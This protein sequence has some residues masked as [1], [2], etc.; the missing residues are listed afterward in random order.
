M[1]QLG[2][3]SYSAAREIA[4]ESMRSHYAQR[5]WIHGPSGRL[6]IAVYRDDQGHIQRRANM[7]GGAVELKGEFLN[8]FKSKNQLTLVDFR[9]QK[10]ASGKVVAQS[11][12]LSLYLKIKNSAGR[13][14]GFLEEVISLDENFR[15]G[16][17]S[18]LGLEVFFFNDGSDEVFSGNSNIRLYKADFFRQFLSQDSSAYFDLTIQGDPFG[19][20]LQPLSWGDGYFFVGLGASKKASRSILQNVKYAFF[21]VVGLIILLLVILSLISS[22][23]MLRPLYDL[24][25]A[26]QTMDINKGRIE[27]KSSG[28]NELGLLVDSFNEMSRRVYEAQKDLR[29]KI[30]ELEQANQEI[31]ETQARLVHTAKM[32]SLGQLVAGIAHELNNPIGFIYSNMSHLNDYSEKLVGLI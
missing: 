13:T 29:T 15:S 18:R 5:L 32:A 19:F 23:I 21:S 9:S 12:D 1:L 31:K 16:L 8:Q 26:L 30:E 4:K 2:K 20:R 17:K 7:E 3:G 14:V 22:K 25:D 27:V 11:V 24:L 28:D 10:E 6:E